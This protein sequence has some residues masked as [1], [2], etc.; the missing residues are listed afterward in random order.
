MQ[1]LA[2]A[3]ELV[4]AAIA[5][6]EVAFHQR[7][8]V[9]RHERGV[10]GRQRLDPPRQ[11]HRVADGGVLQRQVVSDRPRHH[12]PRV[13]PHPDGE[14][15]PAFAAQLGGEAG[16]PLQ[17]PQGRMTAARG[18]ILLGERGAE[19]RHQPV[20]R[21]GVHHALEA[22][23]PLAED[24]Q[25]A[26]HHP[27]PLLRVEPLGQPHRPDHVDEQHRH[28]LALP[29]HRAAGGQHSRGQQIRRV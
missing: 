28:Q 13:Q 18:V 7:C 2:H 15:E 20:A 27:P 21:E 23:D 17:H 12:L 5:H 19:Q 1:R 29:L 11:P 9:P 22:V 26:I 10:R 14:V 4:R 8:R 16:Q 24:R 6:L 3:L 25:T